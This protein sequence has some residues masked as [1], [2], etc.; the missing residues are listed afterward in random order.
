MDKLAFGFVIFLVVV[1][2]LVSAQEST[3]TVRF[4]ARPYARLQLVNGYPQILEELKLTAAQKAKLRAL[5]DTMRR[6]AQQDRR[7]AEALAE[8]EKDVEKRAKILEDARYARIA[9]VTEYE[10]A[11]S[12][13]LDRQQRARLDEIRLQACGCA[14]FLMPEIQERLNLDPSQI[15]RLETVHEEYT[16]GQGQLA[17][18]GETPKA[19]AI[20]REAAKRKEPGEKGVQLRPEEKKAFQVEKERGRTEFTRLRNSADSKTARIL[21]KRQ[22]TL[23]QKMLGKPFIVGG[24]LVQKPSAPASSQ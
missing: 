19:Q 15:A 16:T 20:R 9:G 18:A 17:A 10:P 24:V 6:E 5:Q 23:Y 7:E 4:A 14:A 21:T 13:I 2:P 12:S 1:A 11:L 3:P 8:Q 22:R